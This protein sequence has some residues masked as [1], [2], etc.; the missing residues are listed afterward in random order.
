MRCL[1]LFLI[2]RHLFI[3]YI[4]LSDLSDF[5]RAV[6]DDA[7]RAGLLEPADLLGFSNTTI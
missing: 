7:R 4:Y 5:E 3:I 6:V 1:D 2:Q